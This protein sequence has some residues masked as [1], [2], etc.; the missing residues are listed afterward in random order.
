MSIQFTSVLEGS[1]K[2]SLIGLHSINI[3]VGIQ[4]LSVTSQMSASKKKST[5]VAAKYS[6]Q[7]PILLL[8]D[9]L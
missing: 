4:S 5:R 9:M 6:K 8:K 7:R 1:N 2:Y 3:A